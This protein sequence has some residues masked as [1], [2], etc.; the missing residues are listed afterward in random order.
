K[1][2][3]NVERTRPQTAASI[4]FPL[5]AEVGPCRRHLALPKAHISALSPAVPV[6]PLLLPIRAGSGP[7]LRRAAGRLHGDPPAPAVQPVEPGRLRPG[8]VGLEAG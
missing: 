8:E 1:K 4:G 5:P 7:P 2:R 3:R 6:L